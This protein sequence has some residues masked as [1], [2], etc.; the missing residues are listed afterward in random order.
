MK[1]SRKTEKARGRKKG[2]KS[3]QATRNQVAAKKRE[4]KHGKEKE[5]LGRE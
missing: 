5:K 2:G 1:G 4:M 3:K